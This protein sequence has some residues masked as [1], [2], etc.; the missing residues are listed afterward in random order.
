MGMEVT[1]WNIKIKLLQQ[2][3]NS[4]YRKYCTYSC[5]FPREGG[6]KKENSIHPVANNAEP[7]KTLK[8]YAD[9]SSVRTRTA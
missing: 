5:Y 8:Y 4:I 6:R 2:K 1:A 3:G 9:K 7:G